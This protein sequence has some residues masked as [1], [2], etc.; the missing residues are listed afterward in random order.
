MFCETPFCD[1]PFASFTIQV[2]AIN[3]EDFSFVLE[4]QY[5]YSFVCQR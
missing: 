4:I 5:E 3:G 2:I 1:L